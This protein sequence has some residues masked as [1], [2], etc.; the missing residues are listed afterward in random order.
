MHLLKMRQEIDTIDTKLLEL[1]QARGE[2]VKNIAELKREKELPIFAPDREEE[3]LARLASQVD[4]DQSAAVKL[5]YGILMDVNKLR[6]YQHYPKE[7]TI[8]TKVG[9]ASIRSVLAD[10][11]GTLCRFLSPVAAA[12]LSIADIHSTAM[13]GGK[14]LVDIEVVGDISNPNFIAAI[15]VLQDISESFTVL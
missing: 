1:I 14:L 6:E 11:P 2:V 4:S 3:V 10:T 9:G 12:G 5:L 7:V 8:P 15:A 13:P